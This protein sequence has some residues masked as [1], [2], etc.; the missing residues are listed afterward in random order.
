VDEL[1][2]IVSLVS[3]GIAAAGYQEVEINPLIWDGD[4]WVAVDWLVIQDRGDP[5]TEESTSSGT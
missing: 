3:R 5:V 1:A 2:R 4:A